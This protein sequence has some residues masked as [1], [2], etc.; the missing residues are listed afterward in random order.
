MASVTLRGR[1]SADAEPVA[2]DFALSAPRSRIVVTDLWETARKAA[3]ADNTSLRRLC[4]AALVLYVPELSQ[5]LHREGVTLAGCG[6][7]I[8]G[9]GGAAYDWLTEVRFVPDADV[10]EAGAAAL[11]ANT[12]R[13]L[14][15]RR[16]EED[17]AAARKGS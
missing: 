3:G 11:E 15:Y 14:E 7:S 8:L 12:G 1:K 17:V 10:L 9:L 13:M 5:A 16:L 2:L 4:A 6:H